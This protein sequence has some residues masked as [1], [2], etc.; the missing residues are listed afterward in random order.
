MSNV[1]INLQ[2]KL[3]IHFIKLKELRFEDYAQL[4]SPNSQ[5]CQTDADD[6]RAF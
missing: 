4:W 5:Q 6:P 1:G 2:L 3:S